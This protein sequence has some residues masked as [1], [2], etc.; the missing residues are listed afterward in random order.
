MDLT[1]DSEAEAKAAR[2]ER[3]R[4]N[5]RSSRGATSPEGRARSS[6]NAVQEGGLRAKTYPLPHEKEAAAE[7]AE[8]W[9]S[10]YKPMSPAAVHLVNECARATVVADRADKFREARIKRQ[11]ANVKRNWQRRRKRRLDAAVKRMP[12][13]RIGVY[14]ELASFSL[15]CSDLAHAYNDAIAC[16]EEQGYLP[17]LELGN[18]IY[19]HRIWPVDEVIHTDITAFTFHTLNLACTPGVTPEQ[20]DA[21]MAPASRPAALRTLSRAE[22]I[23]GAVEECRQKLIELL[24]ERREHFLSETERLCKE[25]DEPELERLLAEAETLDDAAAK[26]VARS[27][28]ESRTTF[29]RAFTELGKTLK[30]DAEE[31]EAN[32]RDAGNDD[33]GCD[34]SEGADEGEGAPGLSPED[35]VIL[36]N[37]PRNTLD[38]ASQ[39]V[40]SRDDPNEEPG[41]GDEGPRADPDGSEPGP[42]GVP[43]G[44]AAPG[45]GGVLWAL[46]LAL[47]M[48]QVLLGWR[49]EAAAQQRATHTRS[50]AV[51]ACG[52]GDS[53]VKGVHLSLSRRVRAH[54]WTRAARL[55]V[56]SSELPV[57]GAGY[58]SL[59]P[60]DSERPSTFLTRSAPGAARSPTPATLKRRESRKS[61]MI[62]T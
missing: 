36:P 26:R 50:R 38:G 3:S 47:L 53:R 58:P 32:G 49:A 60:G 44:G 39:V 9:H 23:P 41:A 24:A 16:I 18:V 6:L 34:G 11:Q 21:W 20:L 56:P 4:K 7:R 61:G 8:E 35:R 33:E 17:A 62:G 59:S 30:R 28:A 19:F 25:E 43:S 45:G 27:H 46:L 29:H 10:F 57:V 52:G 22:L 42:R 5:G 12:D 48:G 13:D 37:D 1:P 15:G 55:M 14:D 51:R 31:A 54:G 2:A 40:V